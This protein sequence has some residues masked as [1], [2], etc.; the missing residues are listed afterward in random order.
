MF[1]DAT[2][3]ARK[4]G[5]AW[6]YSTQLVSDLMRKDIREAGEGIIANCTYRFFSKAEGSLTSPEPNNAQ[7]VQSLLN[8][9]PDTM[10]QLSSAPRGRF[11]L[12][13]GSKETW[14]NVEVEDWLRPLFGRGSGQ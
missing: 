13:A 12:Q 10:H 14:V 8:A 6:I 4:Y 5:A 7:Y 2:Q 3:R 11:I 1:K 9:T